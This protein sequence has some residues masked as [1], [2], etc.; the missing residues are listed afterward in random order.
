M[1][2]IALKSTFIK[3]KN[4]KYFKNSKFNSKKY[5]KETYGKKKINKFALLKITTKQQ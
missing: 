4:S 1:K 3:F 5:V 2:G